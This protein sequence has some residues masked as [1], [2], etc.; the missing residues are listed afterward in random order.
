[1]PLQQRIAD[2]LKSAM[3]AQD[4]PR[5]SAL[6]M[7][8]AAMKNAAIADG[9]G[10]QGELDDDKVEA[11]LAT[12]VKRRREAADAFRDAGREEQA[13][14]EEAEAA[15]YATYLPEPL[16]D[17]ELEE[18]VDAAIAEVGATSP[19]EMGE[20]MKTVMAEVG[21]RADGSRVSAMVKGK[22]VG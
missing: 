21:K 6:R 18:L 5:V 4:K 19:K 15:V 2:D 10:P 17:D 9:K 14:S 7:V 1:M 3:K 11:L 12:E 16:S 8:V 22:L 13:A 20:V